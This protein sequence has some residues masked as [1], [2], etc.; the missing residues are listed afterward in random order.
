MPR[1]TCGLDKRFDA[2]DVANQHS[3]KVALRPLFAGSMWPLGWEDD[4]GSE[5]PSKAVVADPYLPLLLR[6]LHFKCSAPFA[7]EVQ[8]GNR[9]IAG[10]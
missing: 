7:S 6:A 5:L 8:P 10:D 2:S 3:V 1:Q 4:D 9:A